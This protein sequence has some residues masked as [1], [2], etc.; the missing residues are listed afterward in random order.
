MTAPISLEEAWGRLFGSVT[1]LASEIVPIDDADGRFLSSPVL[2]RRTQPYADLS[3]MDGF[4]VA[5]SGPWRIVGESRAGA[6]FS[7]KLEKGEATRI[8]TGAA[9]PKGADAI[10]LVEEAHLQGD[11]LKHND[12]TSTAHIRRE[13]FDF[14]EGDSLLGPGQ[15]ITPAK[16]ALLRAAGIGYVEVARR[17]LVAIVECG[18]ELVRDPESAEPSQLPAA[19][20]AMLA[21]MAHRCGAHARVVGPVAD[22]LDALGQ[23]IEEARQADCVVTIGGA[24]VGKHD[25]VRPALESV[26]AELDFWRVAIRPGKPLLVAKRGNQVILGLPGN[27]ASAF[28]TG[29]LFAL[30]LMRAMQGAETVCPVPVALP[31]VGTLPEGG[32]RREFRRA[33]LSLGGVEPLEE[34]DSSALRS[35]AEAQL[36]IDRPADCEEA[37]TGTPVPCYWLENGGIA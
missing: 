15:T 16:I 29:F 9:I 36:L 37:K 26:G 4:A 20:G 1:P 25:L 5:G 35:L 12:A 24:S 22:D 3:A 11:R 33:R 10:L 34:R 28:V 27:P 23:T 17:P 2:A 7:G 30:P 19:N 14:R 18:D 32:P 6:P 21:A 8:S 31:L 13:G